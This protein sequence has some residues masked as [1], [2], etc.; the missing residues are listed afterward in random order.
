[1]KFLNFTFIK[2][3]L[4]FLIGILMGFYFEIPP[5]ILLVTAPTLLVLLLFA[6][7]REQKILFSD[8]FFG[9]V[10]LLN[11]LNLGMLTATLHQPKNLASHYT[12]FLAKKPEYLEI[13]VTEKLRPTSFSQRY[14]AEIQKIKIDT[15]NI[16]TKG[17]ILFSTPKGNIQ[18]NYKVGEIH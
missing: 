4:L 18:S 8:V 10:F 16:L 15:R 13:K 3:S 1:M 17:K 12:N 6:W 11:I 5:K 2:I 14:I 9:I 7:F